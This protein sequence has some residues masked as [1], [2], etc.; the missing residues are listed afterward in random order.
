V[1]QPTLT[2]ARITL[3]PLAEEHL[4]LEITL[5]SDP[6]VMRYLSGRAMSRDE[7]GARHRGRLAV[8]RDGLGFWV[9]FAGAEFL[10]WWILE[11]PS[12]PDRPA[13]D[14]QAELGYRLQR[15]FWRQGY[16]SEGARELIRYGFGDLGLDRIYAQTM[17]VNTASRVT[18][19]AVGLRFARQFISAAPYEAVIPGAELGEVEYALARSDWSAGTTDGA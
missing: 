9:G 15:R 6:E 13:G 12:G 14:H 10:G 5:D 8:A 4:E 7:V 16:A 3:V 1:R 11:P 19:A 17:A 18:M 2:T